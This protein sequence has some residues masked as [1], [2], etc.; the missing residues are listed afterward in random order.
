MIPTIFVR[1]IMVTGKYCYEQT[2]KRGVNFITGKNS[3]GKTS[4][5]KTIRYGLGGKDHGFVPEISDNCELLYIEVE[6]NDKIYTFIREIKRS[7]ARIKV[8]S[9]KIEE[10]KKNMMDYTFYRVGDSFPKFLMEKLNLKE[11]KYF[12]SG[13]P[14]PGKSPIRLSF[15]ELFRYF[16]IRQV[17][18]YAGILYKQPERP[19][20][21]AFEQLLG[22]E[23]LDINELENEEQYLKNSKEEIRNEFYYL[24]NLIQEMGID[25]NLKSLNYL[26]EIEKE[27][28]KL[29][30]KRENIR[31]KSREKLTSNEELNSKYLTFQDELIRSK[32]EIIQK[33]EEIQEIE[34]TLQEIKKAI[35]VKKMNISQF[36]RLQESKVI[37][38][39]IPVSTCPVCF[40]EITDEMRYREEELKCVLCNRELKKITDYK[41]S[42]EIARINSE[43]DEF[44]QVY[45]HRQSE[46]KG[47]KYQYTN[48]LDHQKETIEEMDIISIDFVPSLDIFENVVERIGNLEAKKNELKYF[49]TLN[50][51]ILNLQESLKEIDEELLGIKE[52]MKS[53]KDRKKNDE[54]KIEKFTA[55][56]DDFLRNSGYRD[57]ENLTLS[58]KY[59]PMINNKY[60][61]NASASEVVRTVVAYYLAFLRYSI[62]NKSK[63]PK[64]L[65]IDSPKQQD[66]DYEDYIS[67]IESMTKLEETNK[68]FQLIVTSVDVPDSVKK[69]VARHFKEEE[70]LAIP[71]N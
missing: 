55:Y 31:R 28:K 23:A 49:N 2:F 37:L 36:E 3:R 9:K 4:I 47:R 13:K 43:I 11:V 29:K 50:K 16:Y 39:D 60:Y 61:K 69:L 19:R 10:L 42:I 53:V 27:I 33:M 18:G 14:E 34:A 66:I 17:D 20:L 58:D 41:F 51:K 70:Y 32:S 56:M 62:E 52:K 59:E 40:Q 21:K 25:E 65:I 15:N 71:C 8:F 68:D 12:K 44:Q 1:R 30:E 6:L 5:I 45:E 24:N 26:S 38:S 54:N 35:E 7:G 22:L 57:Y 64:F 67:I 46:L 48:L 63:F